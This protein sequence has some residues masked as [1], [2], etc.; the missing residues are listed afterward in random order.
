M[1]GTLLDAVLIS[2]NFATFVTP[3]LPLSRGRCVD[4]Q[5]ILILLT[6]INR[7]TFTAHSSHA[8]IIK[9]SLL[10][11]QANYN[12]IKLMVISTTWNYAAHNELL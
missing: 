6:L 7:L 4:Y 5:V 1:V 12:I 11:K 8:L 10:V 3:L 2:I 9:L